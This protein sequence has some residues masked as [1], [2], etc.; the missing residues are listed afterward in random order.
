TRC[1]QAWRAATLEGWKL[2]HDPNM[3][4]GNSQV[5]PVEG[6]PNRRLWKLCCWSLSEEEQLDRYERAIYATLSGNLKPL[7]SVCESWEDCVWAYFRVLV[8]SLVEQE[9]TSSGLTNQE[10]EPL[11]REFTEAKGS[12]KNTESITTSSRDSSSSETWRVDYTLTQSP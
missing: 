2:Y 8:D 9:V 6:N 1:G 7:L 4:S 11:P 3:T 10:E 5:T 12:D